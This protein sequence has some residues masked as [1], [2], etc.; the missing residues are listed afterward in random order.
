MNS[1]IIFTFVFSVLLFSLP[2][3][4]KKPKNRPNQVATVEQWGRY[5]IALKGPELG[6]PFMDVKL[7][8]DFSLAGSDSVVTISE[9]E[10]NTLATLEHN[11]W[12]APPLYNI[13]NY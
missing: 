13:I 11:P 6:N 3:E 8:A 7:N 12:W 1:K 10:N 9:I 5:E 4:A 2:I